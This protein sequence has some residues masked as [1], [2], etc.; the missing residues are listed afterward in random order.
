MPPTLFILVIFHTES[1]LMPGPA[2]TG[3]LLFMLLVWLGWVLEN[4][5]ARAEFEPLS[6]LSLPLE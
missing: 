5:L 4:I 6:F 1:F 2:W 3:I